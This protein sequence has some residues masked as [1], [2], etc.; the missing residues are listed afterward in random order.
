MK[1]LLISSAAAVLLGLGAAMTFLSSANVQSAT[2][3]SPVAVSSADETEENSEGLVKHPSEVVELFTS[4]GCSSC[5]PAD[6]FLASL[7]NSPSTLAL[8]FNVTYWDYLGWKDRF[9]QKDFTKRQKQYARALR[10][11][12]VY[13]PQI[14][15]N[16]STHNNIFSRDQ[17]LSAQLPEDR[18]LLDLRNSRIMIL[19]LSLISLVCKQRLSAAERIEAAR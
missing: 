9:G 18:P 7:S 13:T 4:Q 14:V 6:R 16:G 2:I 5:P 15:L 8:S 12:N 3:K 17:V 10:V 1:L 11:G 19:Q